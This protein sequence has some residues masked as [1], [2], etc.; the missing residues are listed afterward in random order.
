MRDG[1]TGESATVRLN[2]MRWIPAALGAD[3]IATLLQSEFG[4][5]ALVGHAANARDEM[6]GLATDLLA[7]TRV[8]Q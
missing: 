8:I 5:I 2:I 6:H 1:M 3:R 7:L 4:H